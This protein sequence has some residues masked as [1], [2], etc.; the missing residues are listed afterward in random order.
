M[1][2]LEVGYRK[3][4]DFHQSW[5]D[6]VVAVNAEKMATLEQLQIVTEWEA[7]LQEEVS[8]LTTVLQSSGAEL[9][10][11]HQNISSLELRIKSKKYSIHQL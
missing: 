2:D 6:K 7:R 10:S 5:M 8:R 3:I 11:A 9:E 1:H 4:T